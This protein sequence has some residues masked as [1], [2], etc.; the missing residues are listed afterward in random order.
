MF[1]FIS[2]LQS[3]LRLHT[4]LYPRISLSAAQRKT[5]KIHR[6]HKFRLLFSDK[7]PSKANADGKSGDT[8]SS[9]VLFLLENVFN[10]YIH[11]KASTKSI[12]WKVISEC[13]WALTTQQSI[14]NQ[15]FEFILL[16][17]QCRCTENSALNDFAQ[18][19]QLYACV[20]LTC[21]R[22]KN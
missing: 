5:E 4:V 17:Y 16:Q 8:V 11:L 9:Q 2:C 19:I 13:P 20:S 15:V 21:Y 12:V 18:Q 22:V 10:Q 6:N 7:H 14:M 1:S 3:W